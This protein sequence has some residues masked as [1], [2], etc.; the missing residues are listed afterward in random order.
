MKLGNG[1]FKGRAVFAEKVARGILCGFCFINTS[2]HV[3]RGTFT[4]PLVPLPFQG[5]HLLFYSAKSVSQLSELCV[6]AKQP[7][8]NGERKK[9]RI[10]YQ[11]EN[12]RVNI[13]RRIRPAS[14]ALSSTRNPPLILPHSWCW[15]QALS[16]ENHG[17]LVFQVGER[18]PLFW[19]SRE[20]GCV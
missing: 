10:R 16:P 17:D 11:V 1:H 14:I 18:D 2:F 5:S 3:Y 20:V 9:G 7:L 4:P 6:W 15:A 8:S 12:C 13:S 19:R